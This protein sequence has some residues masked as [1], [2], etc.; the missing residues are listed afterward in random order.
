M[1]TILVLCISEKLDKKT[2]VNVTVMVGLIVI[3]M[4]KSISLLEHALS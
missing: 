3:L 1:P 2:M 4:R